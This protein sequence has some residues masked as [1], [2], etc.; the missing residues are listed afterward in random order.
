MALGAILISKKVYS[1][2]WERILPLCGSGILPRSIVAGAY[3]A[4]VALAT[5]AGSHSHKKELNLLGRGL[6]EKVRQKCIQKS[7]KKKILL[8]PLPKGSQ[9]DFFVKE[10][11][12]ACLT[13][14]KGTVSWWAFY[15]RRASKQLQGFKGSRGTKYQTPNT[16]KLLSGKSPPRQG[17]T[18]RTC[19]L[20]PKRAFSP[21]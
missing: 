21:L 20:L 19:C 14:P 11:L 18:P 2:L 17:T 12:K 6:D 10:G 16:S 8:P 5:K 7:H 13:F 1:S 15:Q 9:G 3:S 4:E